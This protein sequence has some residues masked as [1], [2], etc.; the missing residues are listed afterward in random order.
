MLIKKATGEVFTDKVTVKF[1]FHLCFHKHEVI[2]Q[3]FHASVI[4]NTN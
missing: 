2:F 3:T 1:V 4:T